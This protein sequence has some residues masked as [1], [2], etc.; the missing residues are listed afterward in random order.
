M[1]PVA[2][3]GRRGCV[4]PRLGLHER[5]R[6]L[7]PALLQR[8]RLRPPPPQR[9]VRQRRS[10]LREHLQHEFGVLDFERRI[11]AV[12]RVRPR[13]HQ[14]LPPSGSSSLQHPSER[15]SRAKEHTPSPPPVHSA[16][17]SPIS[18]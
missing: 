17:R 5:E 14:R 12:R 18:C 15:R 7:R 6:Q 2:A 13:L 11:G 8:R 16:V 1:A 9:L 10:L 3:R 4:R